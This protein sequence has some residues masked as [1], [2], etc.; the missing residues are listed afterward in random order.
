VFVEAAT[1]AATHPPVT[2]QH[3][4]ACAFGGF[5]A[6]TPSNSPSGAVPARQPGGGPTSKS[7]ASIFYLL[8]EKS[9]TRQS[10]DAEGFLKIHRLISDGWSPKFQ[11]S[12][13]FAV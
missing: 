6:K 1:T 3:G 10:S 11:K 13:T 5:G 9:T 7:N 2:P 4:R 12:L 8:N